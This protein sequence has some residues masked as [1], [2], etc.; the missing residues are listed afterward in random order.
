MTLYPKN[1]SD[2]PLFD[3][4]LWIILGL[5]FPVS[6]GNFTL[7]N[8]VHVIIY[9]SAVY[10]MGEL[11]FNKLD[12]FRK[13]PFLFRSGIYI[14]LGGIISG[15]IFLFIS[16][17]L[18]LYFFAL[19]F[20]LDIIANKRLR[21]SFN[22]KGAICLVPFFV[23]LFQTF[24][25]AYGTTE[26]YTYWDGDY[27]FYTAITESIKTNQAVGNAVFHS[28]LAI[29]YAILPFL[30][31]AQLADFS[32]ISSQFALWGVVGKMVPVICLG[33]LSYVIVELFALLFA[34]QIRQGDFFTKQL[35]ASFMLLFLG[36]MHYLKLL[37]FDFK[38]VLFYG[39]GYILPTGSPGFSL[40]MFVSGLILLLIF[41]KPKWDLLHKAV[42][43]F[44]LIV[45][46]TSKV[47]LFLPLITLL[48]S[49]SVFRLFKKDYSLFYVLLVALPCC[50]IVYKLTTGAKDAAVITELTTNGYYREY[51]IALA[52]KY[53]IEGS[54][55]KKIT[56]MFGVSIFMWLSIKLLIFIVATISLYKNKFNSISLIA[57]VLISFFVSCLPAFFVNAYGVDGAGKFLFDARG[58]MGQFTR[59]SIFLITLIA[60]VFVLYLVFV[61]EKLL[62]RKFSF[63]AVCLWMGI[64]SLGFISDYYVKPDMA[65][66][67]WYKEV[68]KE[69][70]KKKPT[71]MAM[72]GSPNCSGQVLTTIGVQPFYCTGIKANAGVHIMSRKVHDRNIIF[73]KIFDSKLDLSY[74]RSLADSIRKQG[75]D[76]IVVTP[77]S[78]GKMQEAQKDSLI[79]IMVGTKWLFQLN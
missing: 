29:N 73:Q 19:A 52:N 17:K 50:I 49:L 34:K 59:A 15:L 38:N 66:M 24:E 67:T 37:H 33:T 14:L 9:L 71:L 54:Q 79:T 40:G 23:I 55:V 7:F 4:L 26:R 74:R 22:W 48:G 35:F 8:I 43:I 58:D 13:I 72:M 1:K 53:G 70:R 63:V 25:L 30:A 75:V 64:I 18:I 39:E 56:L 44:L 60:S 41:E 28:G 62:I 10:Y 61:H 78:L 21:F 76:C 42:I 12:A 57:A 27:Y 51:Y 68:E 47:A 6:G 77:Q 20:I 5:A 32:G 11:V 3:F 31:P 45:L 46:S 16:S 65:D 2:F 36:P 69:F